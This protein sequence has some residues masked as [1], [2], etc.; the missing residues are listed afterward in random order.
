MNGDGSVVPSSPAASSRILARS[1]TCSNVRSDSRPPIGHGSSAMTR[2]VHHDDLAAADLAEVVRR[3]RHVLVGHAHHHD[4]VGVVRVA[5][6][7]RS[8]L[9]P[10]PLGEPEPD[11]PGV[12][13]PLDHRELR[14]VAARVGARLA[15]A[16]QRFA[17]EGAGHDRARVDAD[18]ADGPVGL[19]REVGRLERPH[20]HALAHP[21][22]HRRR[23]DRRGPPALGD[24]PSP[25]PHALGAERHEVRHRDD[26][27]EVPGRHGAVLVEPVVPGR[28][29]RGHDDGVRR[30]T[31]E[32]HGLADHVVDV[33]VLLEVVRLT[34]VRAEQAVRDPVLEHQGE[35]GLE[36]PR[37]R[38][39]ADHDPHPQA[40]LLE[41]LLVRRAFVV[42]ADPGREVRVQRGAREA[43]GVTVDVAV[44]GRGDLGDRVLVPGDDRGVVHHLGQ[45]DRPRLRPQQLGDV[46]GCEGRPRGLE[47]R[48]RHARGDHHVRVERDL[49]GVRAGARGSLRSRTRSRSRA[50][51]G[52][53]SW[54]PTGARRAR[55]RRAGAWSSP[56]A[57]ARR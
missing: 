8:R 32:R 55:T 19:D 51:P 47:R 31:A 6:R 38:A 30:R 5:R 35:E 17:D 48:G 46:L 20:V 49:V 4:V 52:R 56:G 37:R 45:A 9:Q 14:E 25:L 42:A 36:V 11:P 39:L 41:R 12:V 27:G 22:G 53:P 50:G 28:V 3:R 33:S 43:G 44:A 26:V 10:E 16:P 29:E 23:R 21:A 1:A 40:A 13:V 2:A 7:Q 54:S 24:E 57:C 18:H 34:V 15:V